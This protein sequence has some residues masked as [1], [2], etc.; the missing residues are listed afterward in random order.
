MAIDWLPNFCVRTRAE[1]RANFELTRQ[2]RVHIALRVD[3]AGRRL[4]RTIVT[5]SKR[6]IY[7]KVLVAVIKSGEDRWV[8]HCTVGDP[9]RLHPDEKL[10]KSIPCTRSLDEEGIC[11]TSP[12]RE[13]KNIQKKQKLISHLSDSDK[14]EIQLLNFAKV[15][16][17][18]AGM[19][20][21]RS[22]RVVA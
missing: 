5:T 10:C 17:R 19:L 6:L 1:L 7:V 12:V 18:P 11:R 13:N 9:V 8:A 15:L 21:G 4:L 20:Y 16:V 2:H 22:S 3:S 14:C